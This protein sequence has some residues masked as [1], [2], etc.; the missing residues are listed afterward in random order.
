MVDEF[1]SGAADNQMQRLD[2][3]VTQW[4][5]LR[6]AHQPTSLDGPQ[7]RQELLLRYRGAIRGY[8]AALLLNSS[9]VDDVTQ[10]VLMRLLRGDFASADAMKGRFR[11]YLK[12]AVKNMVRT[13]WERQ[14]RRSTV[15]LELENV[16]GQQT[17]DAEDDTWTNEWRQ[18]L[19]ES[20]WQALAQFERQ[21]PGST[22]YTVLRI[23]SEFPNEDSS[24][25]AERLTEITGKT[26][27]HDTFRQQL[28][29]SR[30]RFAQLL[31]EELSRALKHPTPEA[32]EEELIALGL[33]DF[34]RPF[35]PSDWRSLGELRE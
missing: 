16:A 6:L 30:L 9:E 31:I 7:A 27:R 23:R 14:Q 2:Q 8:V 29:R 24:Q 35:L 3:V 13:H 19:I 20:T 11:D 28:R 34:V 21:T 22:Y 18:Q 32:V 10:D 4:S 12:I 26:W 15:S 25:I 1:Q 5:L 17:F 33:M